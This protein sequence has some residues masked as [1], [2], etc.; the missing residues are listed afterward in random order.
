MTDYRRALPL[1]AIVAM[2]AV[3][4]AAIL[5]PINGYTTGALSDL[6]P[7]GFTPAGYVFSIWSVIY[8]ALLAF[9]LSQMFRN[10]RVRGR[11]DS[12]RASVL[13]NAAANAGWIFAWHYRQV[14]LSF[15]I[16]VV[17]LATLV[18]IYATLRRQG[19]P[20][21]AQ[22]TLVDAPFSLYFGWITT[23]AI[24]NL[25]AV[26]FDRRSYP[27]DLSMDSWALVSV[28]AAVAVYVWIGARTRDIV[29]CSVFAWAAYG[30]FNK[31][32]GNSEPVQ[33]AAI[34]GTLAIVAVILWIAITAAAR[35]RPT[36]APQ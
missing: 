14:T 17:I 24:V 34:T 27:F 30:I 26:F 31:P 9:G 19:P 3:N 33:L 32:V 18:V 8:L 15:L 22:L 11:G 4:A 35:L 25:A 1:L 36:R 5:L 7:T 6:N 2:I 12:I 16:M 29:Y 13:V 10:E 28:V 23:A 20:D 21:W